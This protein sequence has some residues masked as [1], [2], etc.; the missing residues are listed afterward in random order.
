MLPLILLFTVVTDIIIDTKNNKFIRVF[1]IGKLTYKH[2]SKVPDLDYISVFKI[3]EITFQVNLWCLN[4]RHYKMYEFE[5]KE[6]AFT[7]G[8]TVAK[9]LSIELL[10]ATEKGN[11]VWVDSYE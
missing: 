7:L 10:D 4:N 8:K 9:K 2:K 6:E 11:F 1:S 3:N 5:N